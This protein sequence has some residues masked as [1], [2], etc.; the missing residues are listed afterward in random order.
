[1]KITVG[2]T[3]SQKLEYLQE[4]LDEFDIVAEIISIEVASGISEQPMTA[5]E[6]T[7]GSINRARNAFS[8]C[9]DADVALG[10]E[11]GYHPN[12]DGNYEMFCCATLIDGNGRQFTSE[13]HRLLLPDFHQNVLKSGE[14]LSDHVRRFL[15]ENPDEHSQ[16][17]GE[18]IR[19]R[20]IFIKSA[21]GGVLKG[22]QDIAKSQ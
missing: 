18:D 9:A 4:V 8:N 10:V 16:K 14:Y 17:V 6:T 12:N 19:G 7:E 22:Y 20:K 15:A 21:V 13:S 11:V 2:T 3:S 1:M 5:V